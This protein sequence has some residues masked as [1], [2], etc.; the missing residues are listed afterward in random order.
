ML[1]WSLIVAGVEFI[2]ASLPIAHS[3]RLDSSLEDQTLRSVEVEK[4]RD[5]E[6][7]WNSTECLTCLCITD[8]IR[9]VTQTNP[10]EVD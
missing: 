4:L 7:D 5:D 10:Y 2:L 3:T 6:V 8:F 1:L 9:R